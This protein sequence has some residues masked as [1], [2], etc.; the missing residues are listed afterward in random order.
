MRLILILT[1]VLALTACKPSSVFGPE[2]EKKD[3]LLGGETTELPVSPALYYPTGEWEDGLGNNW[4]VSVTG[5]N[6]AA[7][8]RQSS[9]GDDD[10]PHQ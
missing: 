6:L 9:R 3:E 2:S 4:D 8:Q 7:R 1:V 5:A 10:R